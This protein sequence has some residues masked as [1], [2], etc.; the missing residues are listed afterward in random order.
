VPGHWAFTDDIATQAQTGIPETA[1]GPGRFGLQPVEQAEA[2][3]P[4]GLEVASL[5]G[6]VHADDGP[7]PVIVLG[8]IDDGDVAACEPLLE[9]GAIEDPTKAPP[10]MVVFGL[11]QRS[12]Q[13]L[14]GLRTHRGPAQQRPG[15]PWR[16]ELAP[17]LVLSRLVD[18]V[19]LT[20]KMLDGEADRDGLLIPRI[21]LLGGMGLACLGTRLR[22]HHMLHA[23]QLQELS[24]GGCVD[25]ERRLDEGIPP[26][27]QAPHHHA[28][29][30]VALRP[31]GKGPVRLQHDQPATQLVRC[32]HL[33]EHRDRDPWV[34]AQPAHPTVAWV[35]HGACPSLGGEREVG[36][37]VVPD[38]AS[39]RPVAGRGAELLD[40][41]VLIRRDHLVGQLAPDPTGL[42]GENDPAPEPRGRQRRRAG[43]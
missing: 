32:H 7:K 9:V 5:L 37:I 25:E 10:W 4:G 26:R 31:G 36:A 29:H 1:I 6:R 17:L 42:L 21:R 11:E 30:P 2:E 19:V 18:R 22:P 14:V 40:P 27:L 23:G 24:I 33:V 12:G 34:V 16:T 41:R 38:A 8:P 15:P 39:E 28:G 20:G 35:E 13:R 3:L 43:T